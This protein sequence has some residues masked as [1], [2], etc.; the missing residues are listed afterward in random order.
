MGEQNHI[1]RK[2]LTALAAGEIPAIEAAALRLHIDGCPACMAQFAALN[3][4]TG[5]VTDAHLG[6]PEFLSGPEW[7]TLVPQKYAV[8]IEFVVEA[9]RGAFTNAAGLIAEVMTSNA[10]AKLARTPADVDASTTENHDQPA[11]WHE[12]TFQT[13]RAWGE[14]T[15]STSNLTG[16]G[17]ITVVVHKVSRYIASAP[18]IDLLNSTGKDALTQSG[19]DS[20]DRY[21]ASFQGLVEGHYLIGIREP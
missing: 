9:A 5:P 3:H 6:D 4:F 10:D 17:I 7:A 14:V 2:Q 16:R 18:I 12:A 20:G 19:L 21:F 15:G 13:D 1:T 8:G 11:L